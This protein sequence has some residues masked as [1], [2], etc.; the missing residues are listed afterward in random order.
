MKINKHFVGRQ[1]NCLASEE[2][3]TISIINKHNDTVENL[4]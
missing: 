4:V 2:D 3:K 1:Q